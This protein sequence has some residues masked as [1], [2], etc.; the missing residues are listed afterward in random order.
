ML[1]NIA[2]F[3]LLLLPLFFVVG[4]DVQKKG[5]SDVITL[6][7][8]FTYKGPE[9]T[10]ANELIAEFCAQY[11]KKHGKK[12]RIEA[13]QVP[14][15][16]L[17]TYVKTACMARKT[18][19]IARIDVQ[20]VLEL[21]YHQ[22]IAKLDTLAN[23]DAK[24][25]EEKAKDY[26]PG[27]FDVNVVE[28]KNRDG[29]F[30]KHLYGLPEQP[31]CL[32]LFWNKK[33]FRAA[34]DRLSAKGLSPDRAPRTWDELI[35]YSQALTYQKDG[36]WRYGFAMQ[37]SLW[38]TMPFFGV[39]KA[40]FVKINEKG[41]KYCTLADDL[42]CAAL[43]LKVDLYNEY[44]AEA[45]AWKSN[46][47][48]PDVGFLNEKYAMILMGPWMVQNFREK[49][50]DFGV[51]LIPKVSD[52]EAKRFHIANPPESATNVG[53]NS[54]VI[55]EGS[56]HKEIAYDFI[57]FMSSFEAQMKWC[58]EL[59]QI[60]AHRKAADVL[61]GKIQDEKYK[62]VQLDPAVK[63]FMEQIQY[64]IAPPPLP[65][66]SYIESTVVNPEME[67]A[68]K[69]EKTVKQAMTDAAK[70]IDENVLKLVNE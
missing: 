55:F 56:E 65:M 28:I 40:Q 16:D 64:A 32:A 50:L 25:I 34:A 37:N 57:N 18:P 35:L 15:D 26:M 21:A 12:V 8:W 6:D 20:K 68:L 13:K 70:K 17:V 59:N 29:K 11:E 2:I 42:T 4:C 5:E 31:S 9:L 61:L 63:V 60:P 58:L 41:E 43:Q 51:A 69:Q 27:P 1:K 52:E 39:Y 62:D 44:K 67:L 54:M 23:F 10:K 3:L 33:L 48:G 38:W 49:N 22:V 46:A 24:S 45:G 53:G 66:Y 19:D 7:A 36:E 30:E 14:F 47:I